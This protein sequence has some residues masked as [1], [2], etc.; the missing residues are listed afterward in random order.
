MLAGISVDLPSSAERAHAP[1]QTRMPFPAS[2]ARDS[3]RN[4][5]RASRRRPLPALPEKTGLQCVISIILILGARH[6]QQ[7][8]AGAAP[9]RS[10]IARVTDVVKYRVQ[11]RRLTSTRRPPRNRTS[12]RRAATAEAIVAAS[13]YSISTPV[14]S[15]RAS[16]V[17]RMSG[18]CFLMTAA[19]RCAV[20][21]PSAV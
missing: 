13:V 16:R 9:L 10:K 18:R 8:S 3:K 19:R 11:N 15:P 1:T 6:R 7:H 2:R 14:G 5:P 4:R 21:S 20:V 17:T 12:Y